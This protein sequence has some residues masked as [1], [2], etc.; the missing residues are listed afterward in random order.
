M[1]LCDSIEHLAGY[2][3]TNIQPSRWSLRRCTDGDDKQRI[4]GRYDLLH[5]EWDNSDNIID[6]LWRSNRD[7]CLG[8]IG[9]DR[10]CFRLRSQRSG[11]CGLQHSSNPARS[12][13][14][15][16]PRHLYDG[17][18]GD[19][20]RYHCGYRDLLHNRRDNADNLVCNLWCP[21]RRQR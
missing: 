10:R 21:N 9:S 2:D 15:S 6:G 17:T 5:D 16:V 13:S 7:E 12:S 20:D 19:H 14:V 4:L 18:D 3:I 8:N 11:N 1:G